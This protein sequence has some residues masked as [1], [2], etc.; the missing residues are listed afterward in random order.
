MIGCNVCVEKGV[1]GFFIF[2]VVVIG[3]GDG[4]VDWIF[5]DDVVGY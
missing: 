3:I 4:F 1:D 5:D 2:D